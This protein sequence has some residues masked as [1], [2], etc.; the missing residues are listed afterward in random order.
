[1][2]AIQAFD[3]QALYWIADHLRSGLLTPTLTFLTHLCDHGE[4]WLT[5]ALILLLRPRTRK[6]GAAILL[7][8]AF[9]LVLGNGAFKHLIARPRP[10]ITYPELVPLVHV[11]G[12][13]CPSGHTLASFCAAA[14]LF[15]WFRKAGTA[16]FLL[17]A[18]IGFTRLYVGV[19]Y[20]TDVLLGAVLG[21]LLGILA[22]AIVEY[23][24]SSIHYA[25]LKRA[26]LPERTRK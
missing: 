21:V 16:A 12:Y 7:A 24:A 15:S 8:M 20:P 6:C 11:G 13:S 5:L 3:I 14:A 10:F 2:Q 18:L 22:A 26:D 19:H 25:R 17:A 1:M 9:G 4:L 23:T